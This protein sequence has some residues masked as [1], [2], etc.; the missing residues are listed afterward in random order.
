MQHSLP[1]T[2]SNTFEYW[3]SSGSDSG[4][5]RSANSDEDGTVRKRDNSKA[6]A[7]GRL[8]ADVLKRQR[9][10]RDEMQAQ[11][12]QQQAREDV[13][14][15]DGPIVQRMIDTWASGKSIRALL[16]TVG[17]IFPPAVSAGSSTKVAE[18]ACGSAADVR[19][20]YKRVA[21][22]IHPDKLAKGNSVEA[23]RQQ[24]FGQKLFALFTAEMDRL[25][26][27]EE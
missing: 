16:L 2:P 17:D 7:G 15:T 10:R 5:E 3:T 24:L 6:R 4:R 14:S 8:R 11:E 26:E 13:A 1:R 21:R 18:L 23:V 9:A 22:L 25:D 27:L 20:A 19:R 12:Q